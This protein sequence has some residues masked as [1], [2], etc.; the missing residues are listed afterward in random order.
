ME[1]IKQLIVDLQKLLIW[2]SEF[3]SKKIIIKEVARYLKM[4]YNFIMIKKCNMKFLGK[5]IQ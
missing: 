1:E 5:S 4:Y 3:D 2:E